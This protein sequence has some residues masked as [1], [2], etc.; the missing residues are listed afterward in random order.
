MTAIQ[1]RSKS[2][3]INSKLFVRACARFVVFC[4]RSSSLPSFPSLFFFF[5]STLHY[6]S[7][8]STF[9]AF[10]SI[11]G[12]NTAVPTASVWSASVT[13]HSP[14]ATD[15]SLAVLSE[16][17]VRTVA[18]S[19]EKT[20]ERT[21]RSCPPKVCTHSPVS[22]D[23]SWAVVSSDA[24]RTEAPSAEKTAERTTSS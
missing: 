19:A 11:Q 23:H 9:P 1:D 5:S 15:H 6:A 22:T 18:S 13:M 12:A 17:A 2:R 10:N 16:D 7:M 20:A 4:S 24:V 14:V 21:E 3:K 8:H